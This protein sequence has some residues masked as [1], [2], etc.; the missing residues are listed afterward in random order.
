MIKLSRD[1]L[2]RN[3][4]SILRISTQRFTSTESAK[5]AETVKKPLVPTST[6]RKPMMLVSE[7]GELLNIKNLTKSKA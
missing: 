3:S 6:K 1:L 5:A 7:Y 2:Y 4:Y